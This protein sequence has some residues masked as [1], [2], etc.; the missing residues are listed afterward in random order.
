MGTGL[1]DISADVAALRPIATHSSCDFPCKTPDM[2]PAH[3]LK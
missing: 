2:Y 3:R 1:C